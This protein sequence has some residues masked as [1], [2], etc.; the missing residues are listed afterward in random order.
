MMGHIIYT[1]IPFD[2]LFSQR[3][4]HAVKRLRISYPTV[5]KSIRWNRKIH[6]KS[7][8]LQEEILR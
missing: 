7:I 2:H 1:F 8:F 6:A 3:S 5:A 4:I